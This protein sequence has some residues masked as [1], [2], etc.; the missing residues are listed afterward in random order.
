M[1]YQNPARRFR[2]RLCSLTRALAL[3]LLLAVA[4]WPLTAQ[5]FYWEEAVRL[6][7]AAGAFPQAVLAGPNGARRVV[8]IW[9]EFE[10]RAG[11]SQLWLSLASW[12]DGGQ[13]TRSRFAGPYRFSGD[14]PVLFSAAVDDA[15]ALAIAVAGTP[16]SMQFWLSADGGLTLHEPRL[17]SLPEAVVS[18]RVFARAAGGWYVFV[19]KEIKIEGD[20]GGVTSILTI[21]YT[22]SA[23]GGAWRPVEDFLPR[24]EGLS[25]D[26]L[27]VAASSGGKDLVIFQSLAGGERP[28]FQLFSR[29]TED[30]G[31]TWSE[32]R[33]VTDFAE[34]VLRDQPSADQH[35][36]QRPHLLRLGDELWYAWERR[37]LLEGTPQ[38][39]VARLDAV[40][41]T[42][43]GSV[44]RVSLG[45]GSC[46]EPRLFSLDGQP[47]V[48]WFD[49]RQ[50][51]NRVYMASRDGGLWRETDLSGRTRADARFGRVIYLD[52]GLYSF[53][54]TGQNVQSGILA[55]LPDTTVPRPRLSGVEFQDG[56]RA[57]RDRVS[58]RWTVPDDSSG[59]LG[60]AWLW[61]RD[62]AAE[63]PQ[64]VM[65]LENVTSLSQTAAEDGAWYF[66]LRAQ[67]YAGNWSS[68]SRLSF[69]RD[70]TP[71]G[72]A[73]PVN[74]AAG[75]D[76]FLLA[77]SFTLRWQPP[78][79]DDVAGYTWR[80]DYLGRLDR[81]PLRRQPAGYLPPALPG[82]LP[83]VLL[84]AAAPAPGTDLAA[85][86]ATDAAANA[87]GQPPLYAWLPATAYEERL[88]TA[89][90]WP[91]P[92]PVSRGANP[93]AAFS[94]IED[95]YYAFTVM[96]IDSVGNVGLPVRYLLR[97]DKFRPF[98]QVA[99]AAI[100][101]D[102]FGTVSLR[103]LGRGF[104][105]DG[106]VTW[107][108]IDADGQ[109]PYDRDFT[110]ADRGYTIL[111]DRV[112][113]GLSAA[114]LPAGRYRVGVFHPERGWLF[115]APLLDIDVSG[116]VK[117]GPRLEPW[118][119]A[120]RFAEPGPRRLSVDRLFLFAAM[121]F[122]GLSLLLS[123]R[124]LIG[125]LNETMLVRDEARAI[126]EGKPMPKLEKDRLLK[127]TRRRGGLAVK[128][129]FTIAFVVI[130][131]VAMVSIPIGI[132]MLDAQSAALARSLEQRVAVLLESINQ[133]ARS[134]LPARNLLQLGDLPKQ[135]AAM[136]EV[137]SVSLTGYAADG[138]ATP[139][140]VWATNDPAVAELAAAQGLEP[141]NLVLEDALTPELPGIIDGIN[142][143][144]TLEVAELLSTLQ[145]LREEG[146]V[147][148]N[149]APDDLV[150]QDRLNQVS[151]TLRDL[152]TTLSQRLAAI[153]DGA[154]SSLPHFD[155][156]KLGR[157]PETFLFYKPVLYAQGRDQVYYR[158]MV[159]MSVSTALIVDEVRQAREGL[160]RNV[161]I[162]AA[163]A[164]AF[165]ILSAIIL[166]AITI[167]P[168]NKI[169]KGVAYIRDTEDKKKLAEFNIV[170]KTRDELFELARTINEMTASLVHAAQESELLTVGKETQKMF[171]PLIKNS[172][173]D[174]LTTGAD[175]R[176]THAF[177]GY[178]EGAKGVSGDYFDYRKL[179]DR[180][181]AFI[182]CD[183]AGKGIPA[184]LIM[185]GV[186]T[187]FASEFQD[188]SF[189][190]N[191]IKLDRIVYK[192]NDFIYQRGFA[193]RFAAFLM[194]VY[195]SKT[196]AAYL[197][198]AGD[199]LLR[200]YVAAES[201]I[202]QHTLVSSPTAGTFDN[203]LVE[204][205][206]PFQQVIKKL[207][208]GDM[209][210]LYTDGFEESTRVRRD[211]N[212][213]Q[214]FDKVVEKDKEGK[215]VVHM[216]PRVEQLGEE[217]I[218]AVALAILQR[219]R[220]E[221][222]KL[223]DPLGL[224]TAYHFDFS[225]CAGSTEEVVMGIAAVEKLFRMVPD[226]A[227]G[228]DE[229]ILVDAK[230]DQMLKRYFLEYSTYCSS[231]KP[232]A[233]PRH[234]EYLYYTNM[235]EDAQYD[236]LTMMI[237]QRKQ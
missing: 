192:I 224:D 139:D 220:F 110:L 181:W 64:N 208:I 87:A 215:E 100:S 9:Q 229:A 44:E 18:P 235:R 223:D 119:P 50:G 13:V 108:V 120:W 184:A 201:K 151:K 118:Q 182:K 177:F 145:A 226:P 148:T 130:S 93:S 173:G 187:I 117:F 54:Q 221:L 94:N 200:Q 73:L 149:A 48:S 41:A 174:K 57:R 77:N 68:T 122:A 186:A 16:D 45:R 219:G 59:I 166:T 217:R 42:V 131:V 128:F 204:M 203:E 12:G 116:T 3:G 216:E 27:P 126:L 71:P 85:D 230:I 35:D 136:A 160:L 14:P 237:I 170:I 138:S 155:S 78:L 111:S 60:F 53:W 109:E 199:N 135:A 28:T 157:I 180:Y 8:A 142:Q 165:G 56:A 32:T 172:F 213:Q 150:S 198:H 193:G 30:G 121:A 167:N 106:A 227:A 190:A 228:K 40:G 115:T 152:E 24:R 51:N 46:A 183:V 112:I 15:G 31:L 21:A 83:T 205:K 103:L 91:L 191:G 104:A 161:A 82:S 163:M 125:V 63:P 2:P 61:S 146:S 231:Q 89:R 175:D 114:D 70:T 10:V 225:A 176:P 236:D 84:T 20:A 80:L 7:R 99:D 33:R 88:W 1:G 90:I 58:L 97:A 98:T 134:F 162:A 168:I 141:G 107:V 144:A 67:D 11:S 169:V 153:A 6:S 195:D 81:L 194:G 96:A 209:L 43:P 62:A 29:Y 206:A 75:G 178:Y 36:N 19:T 22:W 188:W 105:E 179:D 52:G 76:G 34:P 143:R 37:P 95:G 202:V 102:D 164:L 69:I 232:F 39:Y 25:L 129:T 74:P 49:D 159:R 147:L 156:T 154:V 185:V 47:A 38:V 234:T 127:Q 210:L 132:Q 137:R 92:A 214:L 124:Q 123:L 23:D 4:A 140:A 189:D 133:G 171:I 66:S 196:G 26:F 218:Q 55:L 101:R 212:F 113:E 72:Q 211:A 233:D 222:R 5:D 17:I 86:T 207:S 158:G 79:D 65:L 197:C